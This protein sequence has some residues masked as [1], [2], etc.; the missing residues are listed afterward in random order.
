[1]LT[2][3]ACGGTSK[4]TGA[5]AAS[6]QAEAGSD[7][8]RVVDAATKEGRV[9]I[10]SSQP[11][12]PL[13]Q[14]AAKFQKAYPGIHVELVRLTDNDLAAKIDAERQT[15]K[16][17]ADLWVTSSQTV[18]ESR[19]KQAGLMLKP[20][21]PSFSSNGYK[22]E[23]IHSG[24]FFEVGAAIEAIGWNTDLYRKGLKDYS[25]L[26][27]PALGGGK[28][29]V[30]NAKVATAAVD[31]YLYL[32]DRFGDKFVGQLAAQKPRIYGSSLPIAQAL[33][34]GEIAASEFNL[35]LADLKAAGAPVDYVVPRPTWGTRYF[36]VLT[37]GASHQNSAQLLANFMVSPQGQEIVAKNISSVLPNIPGAATTNDQVRVADLSKLTPDNVSK[38]QTQWDSLFKVG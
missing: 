28:I 3:A 27:D 12:D 5:N 11:L 35:P 30:L 18:V 24:S 13:N 1:M 17:T 21:G 2:V 25:D 20:V 37:E 16:I 10:Y 23:Y 33:G 36:G 26:L 9:T 22:P 32:Q 19:A 8:K 29:G 15:G 7:W 31:F 4:H 34:S 6:S 38:Y 14:L